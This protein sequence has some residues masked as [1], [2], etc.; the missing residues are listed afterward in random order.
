MQSLISAAQAR[1]QRL[2]SH[3]GVV[4]LGLFA[5]AGGAAL[6]APHLPPMTWAVILAQ[7]TG[8][9]SLAFYAGAFQ[10]KSPRHSALSIAASD[11]AS[12]VHFVLLGSLAGGWMMV[13][14]VIRSTAVGI[15]PGPVMR[16][17]VLVCLIT[18]WLIAHLMGDPRDL[19]AAVGLTCGAAALVLRDR[20]LA[21]RLTYL[22][23]Q[24]FWMGFY[25]SILSV[26]GMI[27]SSLTAVS[28]V[29]ALAR[30]HLLPVPR[31]TS[32]TA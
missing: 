17:V 24:V 4:M 28:V 32:P 19:L 12:A 3:L 29:I 18:C 2:R 27:E 13:V 25:V 7:G 30:F 15:L 11:A 21:F 23:T 26:P 31:A 9:L 22:G 10:F 6:A 5:V 1:G 16:K 20:P 8:F 14:N